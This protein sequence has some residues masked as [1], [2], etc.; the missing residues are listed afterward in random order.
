MG[1]GLKAGVSNA[2]VLKVSNPL[3]WEGDLA[4]VAADPAAAFVSNPLGWEGDTRSTRTGGQ[5][6]KFLI[7]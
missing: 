7:H 1:G 4:P 5:K 3:G 2:T 6:L